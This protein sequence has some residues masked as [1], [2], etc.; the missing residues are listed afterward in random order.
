VTAMDVVYSL[1]RQGRTLYGFG[2]WLINSRKSNSY[3]RVSFI[4]P[5]VQA[6]V[7]TRV[8]KDWCTIHGT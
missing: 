4:L 8:T 6:T 3:V 5:R 1:K 2:A 7:A